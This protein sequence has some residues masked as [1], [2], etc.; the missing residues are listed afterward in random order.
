MKESSFYCMRFYVTYRCNSRCHYCNVWQEEKFSSVPE[1]EMEQAKELISQ[2]Y[3]AGVRYIDFT[4][5]EPTLCDNLN[6]MIC[7]AKK[8]GIKTE[9]TVNGVTGPIEKLMKVAENVDKFNV[10]LDTLN[11]AKYKRIRGIDGLKKVK[12][13]VKEVSQFRH[14]KIMMVVSEDNFDELDQMIAYA[15]KNESEIYI[16]PVFGYSG[17]ED[18]GESK[19]FIEGII[20]KMY[21]PYTVIM[22]HFMEFLKQDTGSYRPPCSSNIRTLTFAPNGALV[23]PCYH[24]QQETLPWSGDLAQMLMSEQFLK[25]V[26]NTGNLSCCQNCNVIPYFGISFN[27]CLDSF[28]LFQSYSEKLNHLK[29]DYLNHITELYINS[30]DL[31]LQLDELGRIIRSIKIDHSKI[32]SGLYWTE[33]IENGYITDIYK[34]LI[35]EDQFEIEKKAKDCWQLHLVPHHFFD[36]VSDTVFK[37]AYA[38]YQSGDYKKEI[39]EIFQN[40][41]EFQIRWW[42]WYISKFMKASVQCDISSEERWI[43][44]YLSHVQTL[45]GS[46]T[47]LQHKQI[48]AKISN[49]WSQSYQIS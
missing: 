41:A 2:C 26:E 33:H 8:L 11:P 10:S 19:N 18:A 3:H 36:I 23:L 20:S 6:E 48:L 46:S 37:N 1:L 15:Q 7:Y 29:R 44:A 45:C 34:D 49:D 28:F 14:P 9:V 42:K 13:T 5:G 32:S 16:N 27:N 47:V 30:D 31:S 39:L 40:A 35:S 17:T 21:E 25:Y 38:I 4:G 24:A 22:L 43:S 12:E